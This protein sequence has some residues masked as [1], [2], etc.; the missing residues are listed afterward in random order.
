[1]TSFSDHWS[2]ATGEHTKECK[3]DS[4]VCLTEKT[5]AEIK[6]VEV[7]AEGK[8]GKIHLELQS[9]SAQSASGEVLMLTEAE[10]PSRPPKQFDTC[11]AAVQNNLRYNISTRMADSGAFPIPGETLATAVCCDSRLKP[12]A[13]P[14]FLF[15]APDIQLFSKLDTSSGVTTFYDSVCGLPVFKA[16]I[17]RT[18]ADFQA[19]TTEHGWPSFRTA[20][21]VAENIITDKNTTFVTSKCGTHLGSYLPDSKGSRWC[22]DLS[23]VSGNPK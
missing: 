5:L 15:E 3:D 10:S 6:R 11:G 8:K 7:W 21:I 19:D 2:P 22:I 1:M 4:S 18:L 14:Q 23:C 12:Y 20:E 17:G 13:E 9:I 16:P